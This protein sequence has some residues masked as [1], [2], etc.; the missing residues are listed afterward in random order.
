MGIQYNKNIGIVFPGQGSQYVGMGKELF[1]TFPEVKEVF[2]IGANIT[3]IDLAKICFEGPLEIL[4]ETSNCQ[5][6]IFAVSIANFKVLQKE[7]SFTPVFSAGHSLGEYSA[8]FSAGCISIED[9]FRIVQKRAQFMKQASIKNPGSMLAILGKNENEVNKLIDGF[10]VKISN[11]NGPNQIVA[12]GKKSDI[13][14][15]ADYLGQIHVKCIPLKVSGAFHTSLMSEAEQLLKEEMEKIEFN[16]PLFPVYTNFNGEILKDKSQIKDSLLKQIVYPVQ[17]MKIVEN[18]PKDSIVIE[19]GP[20][21]VLS[22][23]INKISPGIKTLNIDD[24]KTLEE[25]INFLKGEK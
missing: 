11:I 21:K 3:G 25:T 17:W 20:K 12:G 16:A 14:N 1:D 4:T 22:G 9:A 6:A 8:F 10:N 15:L 7:I 19:I 18:F 5:I 24:K 2:N 23:L 13:E